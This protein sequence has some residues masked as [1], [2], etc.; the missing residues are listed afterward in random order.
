[1]RSNGIVVREQH[2]E[3]R[4][5]IGE[6]RGVGHDARQAHGFLGGFRVAEQRG[7][8]AQR[9]D[10]LVAIV[11]RDRDGLAFLG[12]HHRLVDHAGPRRH[13]HGHNR[14]DLAEHALLGFAR[15]LRPRGLQCLLAQLGCLFVLAEA[16]RRPCCGRERQRARGMPVATT[17]LG[18]V[19]RDRSERDAETGTADREA[20][21][22]PQR[23]VGLLRL[24]RRRQSQTEIFHLGFDQI[25]PVALVRTAQT[26]AG[27]LGERGEALGVASRERGGLIGLRQSLPAVVT[28]RL[29]QAV[30]SRAGGD[31]DG[32]QRLVD[33][34]IE[35]ID[36]I[37]DRDRAVG[38]DGFDLREIEAACEHAQP[39]QHHAL[40]FAEKIVRPVDRVAQ[41]LLAGRCGAAPGRQQ[42]KPLIEM[43]EDVGDGARTHPRRGQFDRERDAVEAT[44]QLRQCRDVVVADGEAVARVSRPIDEQVHGV[45]SKHA[46]G[47]IFARHRQRR[48]RHDPFAGHREPFAARG[49]DPRIARARHQPQRQMRRGVD[50]VLAVVEHQQQGTLLE[51][52]D[53]AIFDR[54]SRLLLHSQHAPD[55]LRDHRRIGDARQ[56]HEPRTVGIGGQHSRRRPAARAGS[57]RHLRPR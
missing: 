41:C 6:H 27:P 30:A 32:N 20:G 42:P 44:T 12:Q 13:D 49:Q 1:M 56:F 23:E 53:D 14:E 29:E 10:H 2:R 33:E 22:D 47:C 36:G 48:D 11:E 54:L 26:G 52:L 15:R 25:A 43:G 35:Q 5:R 18:R 24:D 40:R 8:Q 45:G 9:L 37:D 28:D 21:D 46:L 38:H 17:E 3:D 34:P 57:C 19:E 51:R 39:P 4:E 50:H 16:K 55:G 31:V 7:E